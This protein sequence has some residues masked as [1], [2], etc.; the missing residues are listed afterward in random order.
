MKDK[1]VVFEGKDEKWYWHC[2]GGNGEITCTS[3]GFTREADAKRAVQDHVAKIRGDGEW[4]WGA[5]DDREY[6]FVEAV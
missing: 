2:K 3:Q 4:R 5:V 1:F 6:L